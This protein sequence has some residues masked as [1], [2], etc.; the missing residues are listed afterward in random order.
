MK[1]LNK[2]TEMADELAQII[3]HNKYLLDDINSLKIAIEI[4][5]ITGMGEAYREG[6]NS[7]IPMSDLSNLNLEFKMGI[8]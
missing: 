4:R 3:V 8:N 5:M 2:A 7:G 1:Y 6:K